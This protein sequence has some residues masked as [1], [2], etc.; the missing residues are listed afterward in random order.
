[1]LVAREIACLVY[2]DEDNRMKNK[3]AGKRL[4]ERESEVSSE[5]S[6]QNKQI[7]KAP[8]RLLE[9]NTRREIA[10]LVATTNSIMHTRLVGQTL[11]LAKLTR[12]RKF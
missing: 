10:S 2:V 8:R 6:E 5:M 9:L 3:N 7:E 1:M 4:R 12:E 11:L